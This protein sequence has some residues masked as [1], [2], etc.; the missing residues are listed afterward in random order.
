MASPHLLCPLQAVMKD[1]TSSTRLVVRMH[2]LSIGNG[3]PEVFKKRL[4][5]KQ[6]RHGAALGSDSDT[7]SSRTSS[8][9]TVM[10]GDSNLTVGAPKMGSSKRMFAGGHKASTGSALVGND[11]SDRLLAA[12]EKSGAEEGLRDSVKPVKA[13]GVKFAEDRPEAEGGASGGESE[14]GLFTAKD[15]EGA[16]GLA[17]D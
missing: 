16:A 14:N 4:L 17:A 5:D 3:D 6:L 2:L 1:G 10:R 11:S 13:G 15:V 9:R 12:R 7:E 8:P